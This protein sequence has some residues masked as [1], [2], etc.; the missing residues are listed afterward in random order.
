VSFAA[1]SLSGCVVA[2]L[3]CGHAPAA[4][5]F[6]ASQLDRAEIEST[7]RG[8]FAAEKPDGPELAKA[9]AA[10][11]GREALLI[12]VLK[13]KSFVAPHGVVARRGVIDQTF[14]FKDAVD[15]PAADAGGR[16]SNATLLNGPA[17]NGTLR[18]FVVYV[19]DATQTAGFEPELE[20][21]G[22]AVGRFVLLVPDEKRDNL[23]DPTPAEL[24]KHS[25]PWRDLLLTYPIDPDRVYMVGS[26][27]GGHATWGVGLTY[28]DRFAALCPCNGGPATEGGYKASGGVFLENAKSLLIDTVYNV[29][30]DHG[31]EGCRYAAK[32]FQAWGYRFKA[33]EEPKF[34]TMGVAEAMGRV[35]SAVRDAHPREIVKRFNQPDAGGCFW[36]RGLDRTPHLWD[37]RAR[38]TSKTAPPDDPL[39]RREF[40]WDHARK[41]CAFLQGS[42]Q[43][44]SI[45]VTARGVSRVR[46]SFDPELVDY[47]AKVT[48]TIN[49]KARPAITLRRDAATMLK[50]VHETGDTARLYWAAQEFPAGA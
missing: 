1:R 9:I 18:P 17:S 11:K 19:P 3:L 38:I 47:A 10:A 44:A 26:G 23:W 46:V 49:G 48:V 28:A 36:L 4:P 12:D 6:Q 30:F 13:T 21:E 25:G 41:E 27:R 7:L 16:E 40:F 14:R 42:I 50:L 29:D 39:K 20:R 45:H 15:P 32:K 37:P 35:G 22:T 8:Y 33:L 34:R 2:A 31:I 5:T 24:R 43:G